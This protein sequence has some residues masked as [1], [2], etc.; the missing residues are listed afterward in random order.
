MVEEEKIARVKKQNLLA[1]W[2]IGKTKSQHGSSALL[3]RVH[4]GISDI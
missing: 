4:R 2:S 3:N 1:Y